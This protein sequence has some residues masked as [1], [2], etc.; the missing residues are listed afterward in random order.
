VFVSFRVPL[1]DIATVLGIASPTDRNGVVG[2][3][4]ADGIQGFDANTTV[5]YVLMSQT[6]P[7]PINGDLGGVGRNYDK[8]A[9]FEQLGTFTAPMSPANPIPAGASL[10]VIEPIG[11]GNLSAN[12]N[13]SVTIS[14]TSTNLTDGVELLITISDS[15]GATLDVTANATVNG[16]TWSVSGLDLSSLADGTL[17]VTVQTTAGATIMD[18]ATVLHDRTPPVIAITNGTAYNTTTPTITGTS[19]LPAGSVITITIDPDNNSAT[20]NSLV[21]TTTVLAGG[22]WALDTNVVRPVSGTFPSGGIPAY[23]R[24]TATGTD[25]A[26]NSTTTIAL[27]RPTVK[28]LTTND[29]TP[30]ITGTWTNIAGD[31][32]AVTVDGTTYT[33]SNGLI[34]SGNTWSLTTH[35]LSV[36][37]YSVTATVTREGTD[38]SD[39]TT[40]ELA[41]ANGP[42]V[43]ITGGANATDADTT[44]TISGTTTLSAGDYVLVRIDPNNDGDLADAIVYAVE[45][46]VGGA[47]TV[48]TGSATPVSGVFPAAGVT[49]DIQVY[50]TATDADNNVAE[51]VQILVITVPSITIGSIE[52]TMASDSSAT[53]ITGDGKFNKREDDSVTVS[54]ASENATGQTVTVT[55]SDGTTTLTRTGTVAGDG[56]WSVTGFDLSTLA[57]GNLAVTAS[58][59]SVNDRETVVHDATAPVMYITTASRIDK[60]NPVLKGVTDL[61]A[62]STLTITVT[63]SSNGSTVTSGTT[64]VGADGRWSWQS[65]TNVIYPTGTNAVTITVTSTATDTAGNKLASTSKLQTVDNNVS[66]PAVTIGTITG[67]NYSA[68]P[69]DSTITSGE[70]GSGVT[71]SGTSSTTSGTVSVSVTDGTTTLNFTPSTN[72][73]WSIS[74]TEAQV[75]NFKNGTLTITASVTAGTGGNQTTS[76]ATAVP[77]L[78]LVTGTPT[79]AIVTPID[80]GILNDVEND[81][82]TISGTTTNAVGSTVTL[83]VSDTDGGTPHVVGTAIV[84]NDGTWTVTG[85]N[86][87]GLVDGT[88]SVSA[89]V[90]ANSQ[91]VS[92]TAS[93]LHDKTP[94]VIAITSGASATDATPVITGTTDLPIG[95]TITITID[96]NNDGDTSDVVTYRVTVQSGGNWSVN[97]ETATPVSG[98]FPEG[99]LPSYAKITASGSD[100][101][102]N[103]A[104][105]IALNAPT[106][107]ALVTNDTTPTLSGTWT[108]LGSDT[109]TVTVNGTTYTTASGLVIAGNTWSLTTTTLSAGT[110]NVTATTTR[111]AT[112]VSDGTSSE[113]V[114]DTIAPVVAITSPTLTNDTTP[115]IS[116][117]TDLPDGALLTIS[118]D[119]DNDSGTNNSVSYTVVVSGGTWSVDTGTALPVSGTFPGT[120]LAGTVGVT[121]S[122][123]DAAGNSTTTAQTLNVD[124]VPPVI[125][126]MTNA[127]TRDTTPVIAGSSD[128]SPGDT[129]TLEIDLDNDGTFDVSYTLTVGPGGSWSVDTETVAPT[130]GTFPPGGLDN[131]VVLRATGQDAIGN[132]TSATKTL[133]IDSSAPV[134]AIGVIGDGN[135]SGTEDDTVVISGTTTDIPHNSTLTIYITDGTR[136]IT[137]TVTVNNGTW[138][139][140]PINLSSL[141]DGT[142]SVTASYIDAGG[143]TFIATSSFEHDT[144]PPSATLSAGSSSIVGAVPTTVTVTFNEAV[145][146]LT[147]TDFVASNGAML[148]DLMQ[149]NSTTWTFTLTPAVDGT[150]SVWMPASGAQDAAGNNNVL[151]NVLSFSVSDTD[152]DNIA[153]TITSVARLSPGASLT[154]ADS[155]TF[156]ITFSED[157]KNVGVGDFETQG[158]A[159]G[160]IQSVTPVVGQVGVYDVVVTNIENANGTLTVSLASGHDVADLADNLLA[161]ETP[162]LSQSYTL[163][164]VAPSLLGVNGAVVTNTSL[165]LYYD[166]SLANTAPAA[167]D[168]TV[169]KNGNPVSVTGVSVNTVSNTI[170]LALGSTVVHSDTVTVSYTAGTNKTQDLAGNF[171]TNFTN[172]AVTNDT[173][174][175]DITAPAA[176]SL[177]LVASSDS[178]ASNSDAITNDDTPTVRISLNGTGATAPVAGDEVKVYL[179]NALVGLTVLSV[180][181][182]A[183]DYVEITLSSLGADGAKNLTATITDVAGNEGE[184][185]SAITLTLDTTAPALDSASINGATLTL[186][187]DEA[188]A[189]ATPVASDFSVTVNG[190]AVTPSAL[191]MNAAAGTITLTLPSAVVH[192]DSVAVSYTPGTNKTQ[193]AAGNLAVSLSGDAVTNATPDIIAPAAPSLTLV[194][195]SDS[196]ASNSDA[197]TNDDTPTVRVS[198]NG[199]GQTAPL[200]GDVVRIYLG[201]T[202][203]GSATLIAGDITNDYVD[204]TTSTLGA[205]GAKS[206]TATVTDAAN[207]VST[208]SNTL[209]LT[210]DTTAPSLSGATVNGAALTLTYNETLAG[211]TPAAGDFSVSVNGSSAAPNSVAVNAAARTVTL[212]LATAVENGDTVT[213]SYTPGSDRTQD[214][215]GNSAASLVNQSVANA[216]ADTVAPAAPGL[217]LLASSDSGVSNS[218]RITNDDTPTLRVTLNGAG[219]AAPVVGDVITIYNGGAPVGGASLDASDI[220]N[221]YVDITTST[222]GADGVKQLTATV[223]DA[224]N[225]I[226]AA[227]SVLSLTLDKTPPTVAGFDNGDADNAVSPGDSLV[228]TVTLNEDVDG[229]TLTAADFSNAGTATITIGALTQTAPGVFTVEVATISAGTL[230]LQVNAGAVV[231]DIAGNAMNTTSPVADST[232]TT[233]AAPAAPPAPRSPVTPAPSSP[234]PSMPATTKSEFGTTP[235]TDVRPEPFTSQ[236]GLG[237]VLDPSRPSSTFAV[238]GDE[239]TRARITT[240]RL[241]DDV[242]TSRGVNGFRIAV[243]RADEPS[244]LVYRGIPD[245]DIHTNRVVDFKIP[246]D[247]FV[248][249]NPRAVVTLRATLLDGRALP[250]WLQFDPVTGKFEGKAPRGNPEVLSILVVA[251]DGDGREART[252]FRVHFDKASASGGR[253]GL[254]EQLR[255][256]ADRKAMAN[257]ARIH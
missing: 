191:S 252:I 53:V 36:G 6:Q 234:S 250:R 70:I 168:F 55:I 52:T 68:S 204:I 146:G 71:I 1:A 29:T 30:T 196:G 94:P 257:V 73:N 199:T 188:L 156:R 163:D 215:A 17:T 187:Y 221:G 210:L 56:T 25:A 217:A 182:I 185:S 122:G 27:N 96:P 127:T 157:M 154:N 242:L 42:A 241:L 175:G 3:R 160:A 231:R 62:G 205:D 216:T 118:V 137:D 26:G 248:H 114:V 57:D 35:T 197:I 206:L 9:T 93:V 249:T 246:I 195:D 97:T 123:T 34:I 220:T 12:E 58:V 151:S 218:D 139:I 256:A 15:D 209:T 164:N 203:V 66:P 119:P 112:S 150:T 102:G 101:A 105:A 82:V 148:D 31:T 39:A 83:T 255:E 128:L 225:N 44:P 91:T 159:G 121:A 77:S 179:G 107:D 88:L 244:L 135:I 194:A 54:G 189:A 155:V 161:D 108:N 184:A 171:A 4:G 247:A 212:T 7:G 111:S 86:L 116:G 192:G 21:Y 92:D 103:S 172:Q 170:T 89:S 65:S 198:L 81:S 152:P 208:T 18:A 142:I 16:N 19:D 33:T 143:E 126:I 219:L 141:D 87:S 41:I 213:V 230:V 43:T 48:D 227:S 99:G 144:T 238:L 232:T 104:S 85:L 237:G 117:T 153:P 224:S 59:L 226:S 113:L 169:L 130:S 100:Q 174:T 228:F 49:G 214:V 166:E 167:G 134:L 11:D 180:S 23:S 120:G 76:Y 229:S 183:N 13:G 50:V 24:I 32:L 131:T 176:P 60:T 200:A 51:T 20:N 38:L 84:Q 129:L 158:T 109:L 98:A 115:V 173:P 253:A 223:T 149:V 74:L 211:T 132:S 124:T 14:G 90:T 79:I 201:G 5:R 37:T 61:P 63:D 165:V 254:S 45:V 136:T 69:V 106:V 125:G 178:G 22:A 75:K 95:S 177:T 202:E 46:G 133:T 243:A 78:L 240:V 251:R 222:L 80:N 140:S 236:L 235:S 67:I 239:I 233:V 10:T 207:N 186:T 110:Y 40:G 162:S 72:G 145:S 245:Q 28:G 2:P 181:D 190:N 147:I 138:S 193:D 47:W 64:T 8:N